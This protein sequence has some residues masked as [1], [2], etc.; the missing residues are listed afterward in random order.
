[1]TEG[2]KVSATGS[3]GNI[4]KTHGVRKKKNKEKKSDLTQ[5]GERKKPRSEKKRRFEE[6]WGELNWKGASGGVGR[7]R[8]KKR[9]G[10][11]GKVRRTKKKTNTNQKNNKTSEK[12]L[13]CKSNESKKC[14]S[15]RDAG[16]MGEG[17][18]RQN[19]RKGD[20]VLVGT[21]KQKKKVHKN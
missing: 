2:N 7:R 21:H 9:E 11:R 8:K 13:H 12:Q 1:M 18:T 15:F 17:R 16:M 6:A 19:S 20:R 10:S 14:H 3:W 4:D 5:K